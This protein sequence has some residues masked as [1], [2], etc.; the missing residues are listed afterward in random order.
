M[1]KPLNINA[2]QVNWTETTSIE[3]KR[4]AA[5]VLD[6]ARKNAA[7]APRTFW[8]RVRDWLNSDAF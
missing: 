5:R 3:D 2:P 6:R 1:H 7:P 4:N 8:Q